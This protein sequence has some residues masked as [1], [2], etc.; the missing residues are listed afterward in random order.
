MERAGQ[1]DVLVLHASAYGTVSW[2]V[3]AGGSGTDAGYGVAVDDE[4]D[5]YVAGMFAGRSTFGAPAVLTAYAP[6]NVSTSID[7]F[8]MKVSALTA[9]ACALRLA[10]FPGGAADDEYGSARSHAMS[11]VDIDRAGRNML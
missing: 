7:T 10:P 11:T 4:G 5:A 6:S 1:E 2:A 3:A 8:V 9:L